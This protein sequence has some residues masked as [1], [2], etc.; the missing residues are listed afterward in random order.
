MK[1]L[2]I[3]IVMLFILGVFILPAVG[4][5]SV[6]GQTSDEALTFNMRHDGDLFNGL[7]T[8]GT[9]IDECAGE[10]VP[11][12][13]FED[14]KFIFEELETP[15]EGL[16]PVY[17]AAGCRDCHESPATGGISQIR[18]LRA[19]HLN[20]AGNF[21]NPPSGQSL[22][23]LRSI[24]ADIQERLDNAPQENIRTFRTTL[25]VLG[26]GFVEAIAN[27]TFSVIQFN[28]PAGFVG[29]IIGVPVVEA[30]NIL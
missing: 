1:L 11:N 12:R 28:Q 8:R 4:P 18:E 22:I 5:S 13:S 10:P 20:P 19:G 9:P 16:G 24:A 15:G 17:N 14:N 29:T 3:L 6:E 2:K 7:G 23:Q 30:N 25:N 21:V 26:D 27:D